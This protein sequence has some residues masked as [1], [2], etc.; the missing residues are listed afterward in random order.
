MWGKDTY[1]NTKM[2]NFNTFIT[3]LFTKNYLKIKN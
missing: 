1:N 2:L 3:E